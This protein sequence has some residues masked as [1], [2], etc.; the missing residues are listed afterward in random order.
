V[1]FFNFFS[2]IARFRGGSGDSTFPSLEEAFAR[3]CGFLPPRLF[4][5]VFVFFAIIRTIGF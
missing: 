2:A 3:F 4:A 5:D 1:S